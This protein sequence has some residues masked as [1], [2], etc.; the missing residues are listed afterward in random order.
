MVASGVHTVVVPFDDDDRFADIPDA[1]ALPIVI[2]GV[3]AATAALRP[4]VFDLVLADGDPALDAL[5][6]TI[7]L[8]PVAST[9]LAVLLRA[10]AQLPVEHAIAAE[11]AV[12]SML[13]AGGDAVAWRAANR[14]VP[15]AESAAPAVLGER[16]TDV[17]RI[18]LNRPGRHNA[19]SR[20]L[21]DGLCE[22]LALAA[23]D[24][25]IS[26]VELAG[27]GPS[28]CSGG[29]LGE[30]GTFDDPA[31]AH[32]TRLARSAARLMARVG[33]RTS[34]YLHGACMGAG[35]ELAA[36]ARRVVAHPDS[37]IALPEIDLGLIPGAGG[38]ASIT[39][40]IG[41]QRCAQLALAGAPISAATA[42]EWGL[43]DA[44][45]P[46]TAAASRP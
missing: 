12:Y 34:V 45:S 38:T 18:V 11:S 40:R 7:D 13:Q 36:F 46:T 41:R 16:D 37:V 14:R 21:R 24:D 43:I 9:A 3:A 28:F 20:D 10:S 35:I 42:L 5:L 32:S 44:I 39:Q 17:L 22:L 2:V 30:F 1:G 23:S 25:T 33:S 27:N 4:S 29:D 19:F 31:A 26:A 6:A 15:S 8:H